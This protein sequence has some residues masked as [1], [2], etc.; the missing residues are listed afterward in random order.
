MVHPDRTKG[1][2]VMKVTGTHKNVDGRASDMKGLEVRGP[3]FL[4][5]LHRSGNLSALVFAFS[6]LHSGHTD[7]D[8]L[9]VFL[10][11]ADAQAP[12]RVAGVGGG[13]EED[14]II[15][16]LSRT[17]EM[18][19]SNWLAQE[20]GSPVYKSE[21]SFGSELAARILNAL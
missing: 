20:P 12:H 18:T 8:S 7:G 14:S 9:L 13:L 10:S 21:N 16:E 11:P 19:G 5:F 1:L 6:G 4:P 2:L 17:N 15:S 3:H